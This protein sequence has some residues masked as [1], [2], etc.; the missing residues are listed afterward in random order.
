MLRYP[1]EFSMSEREEAEYLDATAESADAILISAVVDGRLAGSAGLSPV[2]ALEKC[3]HRAEF[4]ISVRKEF[5]GLGIGSLLLEA[6]LGAARRAGYG[7]VELD[8]VEGNERACALYRKFG[9][10]VYGRH[11]RAFRL[12][13][14][15]Y[16]NLTL[17]LLEL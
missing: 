4:G 2:C 7:Q 6:A 1:E 5:W 12:R 16:Q 8:V 13:D 14:G 17:M 3:A 9:F 11:E 10:H 15:S